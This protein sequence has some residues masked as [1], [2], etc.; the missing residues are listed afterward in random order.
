MA[1]DH[2]SGRSPKLCVRASLVIRMI[3]EDAPALAGA[4]EEGVGRVA[5]S[6]DPEAHFLSY[7]V[8]GRW[9]LVRLGLKD[10][11]EIRTGF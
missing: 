8:R 1:A 2:W 11:L 5:G 10:R 9:C 6:D 4:G 7:V 3:H